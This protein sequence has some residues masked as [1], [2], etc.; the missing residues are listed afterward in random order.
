MYHEKQPFPVWSPEEW[1]ADDWDAIDYGRDFD[2]SR[3]FF[4]QF[5]ELL[6][7]V[8]HYSLMVTASPNCGYCNVAHRSSDCYFSFGVV[9]SEYCDYSGHAIWNSRESSDCT[10][11]Y[12]SEYCYECVDILDSNNLL[13]CQEC[14]SCSESIALFDCRGCVNCI[15]CVGLR[16]KSYHIFNQ[17]VTKEEYQQFL[18]DHPLNKRENI[19]YILAEQEKLK[20]TVPTPHMFGTRNVNVSGN[21]IYNGKNIQWG[22]DVKSGEDSKFGFTVR[23]MI[24]S[25]DTIF[26]TTSENSYETVYSQSYENIACHNAVD[27]TYTSYSQFCLNSNNIFGCVGLQKK[28]YCI[29]NKQYTKEE[30][31]ELVPK[32]TEHMRTTGEWGEFFP[33]EL[34]PFTYNESTVNEYYPLSKEEALAQEYTWNDDT[35]QM[36]GQEN[37]VIDEVSGYDF[38]GVKDKIFACTECKRNYRLVQHEMSL[39]ERFKLPLPEKCF[40][41]RHASRMAKRLPRGI[42]YNRSCMCTKENHDHSGPC[43]NTFE[44]SYAPERPEVIYCEKCYQ[45]EIV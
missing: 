45:Q 39:Y 22:F 20:H 14:E 15:G 33:V 43:P 38:E 31:E 29:F 40:F 21:H 44:T 18:K 19:N 35:P 9:D 24:N 13:F 7:S 12:K 4:S 23:S 16:N 11:L 27:C 34:A 37:A 3:S 26:T 41:C 28:D 6:H 42:M 17:Q 30:Y 10:Y 5:K 32:I 1:F 36:R 2:F 8:P 25:Y